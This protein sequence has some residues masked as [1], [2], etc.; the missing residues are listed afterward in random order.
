[1]MWNYQR[2]E[3]K[4]LY[5]VFLRYENETGELMTE[6]LGDKWAFSPEQAAKLMS[7]DHGDGG[8]R[9]IQYKGYKVVYEAKQVDI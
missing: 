8:E 6:Y 9:E 1:M 7:F 5:N 4:S 2:K 3:P